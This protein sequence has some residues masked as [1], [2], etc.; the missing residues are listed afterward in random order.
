[1]SIDEWFKHVREKYA[2]QMQ[3]GKGCTACC[4]GLFD[5][6]MKDA[7][8]VAQGFHELSPELQERVRAKAT[9]IHRAVIEPVADASMPARFSEDDPRIDEI[10]EAAN[11]PACPFLGDAGE[12]LIYEHR[13]LSCRL[14]GVPMVDVH[15]GLFGDWCELNFTEGVSKEAMTDLQLD[16]DAINDATENS[17]DVTFIAS[18]I[19]SL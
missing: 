16:Y 12:C 2:A 11:S 4:Y 17:G 7:A 1:M 5:I 18:V 15:D 8:A 10:V 6:S 19:A 13:P 9:E 3:C 14:E